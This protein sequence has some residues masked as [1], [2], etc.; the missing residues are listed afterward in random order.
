MEY[1]STQYSKSKDRRRANVL[2]AEG[3]A[4]RHFVVWINHGKLCPHII[5]S[6]ASAYTRS[7]IM[8]TL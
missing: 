1:N 5:R 7:K 4:R 3:C 2:N 6:S 8:Y